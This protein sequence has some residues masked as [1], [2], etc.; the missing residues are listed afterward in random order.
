MFLGNPRCPWQFNLT[1]RQYTRFTNL[2]CRASLQIYQEYI[3]LWSSASSFHPVS[4]LHGDLMTLLA[5]PSWSSLSWLLTLFFHIGIFFCKK[6]MPIQSLFGVCFSEDQN[7]CRCSLWTDD[8]LGYLGYLF[9]CFPRAAVPKYHR[10]DGMHCLTVMEARRPW[11]KYWQGGFLL[12]I[13]M[14]QLLCSPSS[15]RFSGIFGV[16]WLIPASLQS[17]SSSSNDI[18]LGALLRPNFCFL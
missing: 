16:S 8:M 6:I 9:L 13:V 7:K 2:A 12:S 4:D 3:C 14:G 11:Y 18:L 17:L 5:F 1:R 10:L 15:W